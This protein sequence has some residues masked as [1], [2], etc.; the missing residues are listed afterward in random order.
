MAGFKI[1]G[2][3]VNYKNVSVRVETIVELDEL[4]NG[5]HPKCKNSWCRNKTAKTQKGFYS[6][7]EYHRLLNNKSQNKRKQKMEKML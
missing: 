2:Y 5:L 4:I 3:T 6:L 7:C 1:M